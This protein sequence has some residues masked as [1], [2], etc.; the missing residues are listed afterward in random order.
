MFNIFDNPWLLTIVAILLVPILSFL[1]QPWPDKHQR[2]ILFVPLLLFMSAF[3]LD[4]LVKTDR[5]KIDLIINQSITAAVTNNTALI[6]AVVSED[7]S[8]DVH[9]SKRALL[10][11]CR[12]VFATYSI[13]KINKRSKQ[14]NIVRSDATANLHYVVHLNPRSTYATAGTIVFVK[15][16]ISFVKSPTRKWY[17]KTADIISINNQP[18]NWNSIR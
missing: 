16:E 7:Y 3:G 18:M 12:S 9:K 11:T 8:D 17:V 1:R 10:S 13:K 6:E 14:I 2:W 5:E 4:F 15:M